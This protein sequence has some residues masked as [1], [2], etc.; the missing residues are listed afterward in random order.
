VFSPRRSTSGPPSKNES[1]CVGSFEGK[2]VFHDWP[3]GER[4]GRTHTSLSCTRQQLR[5]GRC[6]PRDRLV[7]RF[8]FV[9]R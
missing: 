1:W 6:T 8:T 9:V 7:G 4:R 2:V 3:R 5:S